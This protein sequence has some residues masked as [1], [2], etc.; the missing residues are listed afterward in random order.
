MLFIR[1]GREKESFIQWIVSIQPCSGYDKLYS[2]STGAFINKMEFLF[3]RTEQVFK[4]LPDA[5]SLFF[6]LRTLKWDHLRQVGFNMFMA[7][8]NNDMKFYEKRLPFVILCGL[9]MVML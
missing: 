5:D 7:L 4:A 6:L 9:F 8:L 3:T 2:V 1:V